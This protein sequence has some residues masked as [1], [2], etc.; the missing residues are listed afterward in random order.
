MNLINKYLPEH[1]LNV[2]FLNILLVLGLASFIFFFFVINTGGVRTSLIVCDINLIVLILMRAYNPIRYKHIVYTIVITLFLIIPSFFISGVYTNTSTIFTVLKLLG[3]VLSIHYLTII[4]NQLSIKAL[5]KYVLM[6]LLLLTIIWQFVSCVLFHMPYG[7]F[8]NLHILG[9]TS[10]LTL[11]IVFYFF[12]TSKPLGRIV[13]SIVGVL[14]VITLILSDSRAAW[15]SITISCVFGI[16]MFLRGTKRWISLFVF[17]SLLFLI[18]C[19]DWRVEMR[20]SDLFVNINKQARVV[21]WNDAIKILEHN[22]TSEWI[23]GHGVGI[24]RTVQYPSYKII[25]F[26]HNFFLEIVYDNG[27][28]GVFLLCVPLS[29]LFIR[30][31]KDIIKVVKI[32]DRVFLCCLLVVFIA[33]FLDASIVFPFYSK[34]SLYPF[35]L[36]LG[37]MVM[38]REMLIQPNVKNTILLD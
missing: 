22:K 12:Y 21:I 7:T 4:N 25:N 15:I 6:V 28:I 38:Y 11:P 26:P 10:I 1:N 19:I 20:L 24:D 9:S 34:N 8:S 18:I 16:I 17:V 3:I 37:G 13:F 35:S 29:F 2:F 14:N 33:W 31:F 36:I 32:N 27:I 5:L 30:L 23:W